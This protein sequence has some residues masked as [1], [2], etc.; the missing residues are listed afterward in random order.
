MSFA[1]IENDIFC[2][3]FCIAKAVTDVK[4]EGDSVYIAVA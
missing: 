2:G 3:S 4:T 1:V